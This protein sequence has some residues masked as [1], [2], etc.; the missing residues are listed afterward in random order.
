VTELLAE[1]AL[2]LAAAGI[3][4]AALDAEL[5]LR[6][7]TDWDR[8]RIISDRDR[9]L[10]PADAEAFLTLVA[11][12][13]RRRP[14]Q[15]LTGTQAFWRHEFRVTPDV[16][17]PRPETEILVEVALERLRPLARPRVLDVGTGSGCIALSLA[18]ELPNA[19]VH[20]VDISERALAVARE[21]ARR[22]RLEARVAFHAGDLLEPIVAADA[23][24]DV[25]V[26]NPPYV[27]RS[28]WESLAPEVRDHEPIL[29]LVAPEGRERLYSRL[30]AAAARVL[31]PDGHLLL[32]I[33]RGM[34]REVA[35]ACGAAGLRVQR[36]VPD[37]QG[38]GRVVEAVRDCSPPERV[39]LPKR[40]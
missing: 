33:G 27:D 8:A 16:L 11:E 2:R 7:V 36:V 10:S 13:A 20:A 22:L 39:R 40:R 18:A 1:A 28:E 29:A 6:H 24:V 32:E 12:R 30:A 35:V 4:T 21:N 5:L 17:I 3:G 14:L 38:I 37:L 26:A 23:P 34:D 9:T 19:V 25:V 31:R 15:H